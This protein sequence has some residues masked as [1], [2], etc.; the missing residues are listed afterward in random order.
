MEFAKEV[1]D[2]IVF[3]DKSMIVEEYTPIEFFNNP[4]TSRAKDFLSQILHH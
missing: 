4:K 3:M 2:G 1:G